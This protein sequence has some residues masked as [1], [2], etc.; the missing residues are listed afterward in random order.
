MTSLAASLRQTLAE[1]DAQ[2]NAEVD[3][4]ASERFE[5]FRRGDEYVLPGVSLVSRAT[6]T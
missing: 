1:L 6:A 2:T 4:A 5:A 3:A